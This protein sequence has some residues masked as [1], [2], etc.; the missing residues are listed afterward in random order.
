LLAAI[1]F[2]H[3]CIRWLQSPRLPDG[4]TPPPPFPTA[5]VVATVKRKPGS[6]EG[7]VRISDDFDDELPA[8]QQPDDSASHR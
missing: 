8:G 3:A 1:V 4:V 5:I 6:W 2:G 7:Q